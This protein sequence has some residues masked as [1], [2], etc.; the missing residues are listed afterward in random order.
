MS[1]LH[2]DKML[3]INLSDGSIKIEPTAGYTERFLGARGINDAIM[4]EN[5]GPEIKPYDEENLLIFGMGPLVG[6]SSPSSPR[7]EVTAKSP[8]TGGLGTSNFGGIWGPKVRW[9]GYDN[10]VIK[11]KSE[12][13]VYIDIQYDK[14]EIK[15]AKEI[16]GKDTYISQDLIKEELNDAKAEIVCI[17]PAGE[18][19]VNSACLIHRLGNAAGRTGMGAIMGS[20]KLKA[21]V[22]RGTKKEISLANADEFA[23]LSREAF[24]ALEAEW[25]TKEFK[26]MGLA[27]W[28]DFFGEKE[29]L[30]VGNFR[31]SFWDSFDKERKANFTKLW[32][33]KGNKKYGCYGC[34]APCMENYKIEGDRETVI[35]CCLYF[36][37]WAAKITDME[38]IVELAAL[39]QKNGI[40]V[41]SFINLVGWMMELY[42]AGIITKSDTDGTA[43]EWGSKKAVLK[44]MDLIVNRRGLGDI[45]AEDT[46]TAIKKLGPKAGEYMMHVNGNP[47]YYLN[48]QAYKTVGLSAAVGTRSDVIRG[49]GMPDIN[50]RCIQG[51]MDDGIDYD[52]VE[53]YI[54]YYNQLPQDLT[55]LK[56]N[57]LTLPNTYEGRGKIVEYYEDIITINDLMGNCKF[58]GLWFDMP[59]TPERSA[60]LYSAGKGV[61]LTEDELFKIA[62]RV[63]HLE[64]AYNIREGRTRDDDTLPKRFFERPAPD[65]EFEGDLMNR[66]K[67]EKMKDE[68]YT[69]RGWDLKTGIPTKET[70]LDFELPDI[71]ED[72]EKRGKLPTQ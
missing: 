58:L 1:F 39:C 69:L 5:V 57:H 21:I 64:R 9:A 32:E 61:E 62:K 31:S 8:V 2:T 7:T 47:T 43:M 3:E 56:G 26:R 27:R 29:F 68:Y 33:S 45:L 70:F 17:G 28:E 10:V 59:L 65:G 67:F 11:G 30:E 49:L 6:T 35:S 46:F 72:L 52:E 53:P 37:P 63:M 4:Y 66:D 23:K 36:V 25:F 16:W 40:D 55:G 19:K 54:E 51:Y 34:P 60:N 24:K 42:D 13:P 12:K 20:K 18:N 22:A 38:G 50:K 14:V 48:H 44:L 41:N 71:A 15:D